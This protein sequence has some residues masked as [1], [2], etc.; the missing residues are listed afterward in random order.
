MK[1]PHA[2]RRRRI[3]DPVKDPHADAGVNGIDPVHIMCA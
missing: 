3:N 1:D 2:D